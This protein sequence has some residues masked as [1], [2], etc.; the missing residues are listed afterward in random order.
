M[1][2][3]QRFGIKYNTP[4]VGLYISDSD[5]IRF[6]LDLPFYLHQPIKFIPPQESPAYLEV[7]RWGN[8]N[9]QNNDHFSFPVGMI[10]DVTLWFMHYG[11]IEEAESKWVRRASRVN[12][13]DILIK[14]SQR[15]TDDDDTVN[16]FLEIPYN[17][18]GIV[19]SSCGITSNDLVKLSGWNE[20]KDEGGDEISFTGKHINTIDIINKALA[21]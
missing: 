12:I 9:P 15:Y 6:C 16:H 10:G 17:K 5:F 19:D 11:S 20:L 2:F 14:W 21:V 18:I 4:T 7:C 1:H 13:N 8:L 3:Y